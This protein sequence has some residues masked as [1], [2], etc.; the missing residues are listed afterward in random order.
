[1]IKN[2][3]VDLPYFDQLFREIAQGNT[4]VI[5]AFGL[6]VHWGYWQNPALADGSI[7]DFALAAENLTRR[8]CDAG[9]AADGQSILDC[10]CGF[11]GTIAS[12]SDR[13]HHLQLTGVNIDPRQLARA[14]EQ[15]Q[16]RNH[17]HIEF[18]QGDAC[19]LNFADNSFDL[20]L[21]V[22]CIFHF[23][24]RDRFFQEAWRVLKPGGKL[25]ICDFVPQEFLTPIIQ[26]GANFIG[27]VISNTYGY[28][29]S[30]FSLTD[31]RQ[32]AKITGFQSIIEEDITAN[33]IPTYQLLRRLQIEGGNTNLSN[34]TFVAE[35]ISRLGIVRYLILSFQK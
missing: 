18:V 8:V 15:V 16:P 3:S 35:W 1:M 7:D 9:G 17:N 30:S 14:R 6:H 23:P 22:E 13:F 31:Y 20:V 25:A 5:K 4:E 21:A 12:L 2:Q 26:I 24:S 27:P 10:G 11:G 28:V 33:T 29:D 34:S 19:Q 32:L